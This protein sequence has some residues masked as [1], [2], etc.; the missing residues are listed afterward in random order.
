V[1]RAK[2][3]RATRGF[4]MIELAVALFL[5]ALLF[6]TIFMPLQTQVENRKIADTDILLD[7]AREALLGYASA[8]GYF[9]CPA[10]DMSGGR[11]PETADHVTGICP[12]YYGFLPGAA[13]GI[14]ISD[15]QGYA[16]DGWG[17][18]ANRIRYAVASQ[19]VGG[20]S[21]PFTRTNGLRTAGIANLSDTTA[22]FLHVCSS[23][24]GVVAGTS[25][26]TAGTLVST[27]PVML[28]SA[29]ANAATGGIGADEAQNPNPNGGSADRIF[30]SRLRATTGAGEFDDQLAWVP[31][32]TLVSRMVAA[33]QLP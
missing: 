17:G 30:V 19:T 8:N 32:P 28:W 10:D 5:I 22:S 29:G 2:A 13:L 33:G 9:P 26:G 11:E 6:G 27:A 31:M 3:C 15:A 21:R 25:C 18:R 24:A 1:K 4:S 16:L 14:Q 23:A 12:A 7:K 20:V